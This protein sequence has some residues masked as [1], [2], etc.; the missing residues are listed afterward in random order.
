MQIPPYIKRMSQPNRDIMVEKRKLR[1]TMLARRRGLAHAAMLSANQSVARH[2]GDHPILAFAPSL[3]GYIAIQGELDVLPVFDAMQRFR[4]ITA[5]PCI[6]EGGN[7]QFRTWSRGEPLVRHVSLNVQEP[8]ATAPTIIPTVV[9]VP[10]LAFDGDG[11]RLGY[12]AG[13][14]DRTMQQM[15]Q[16]PTP[17][18]FIGVGHSAQE[19]DQIPV[20]PHDERLDGILTELGVSMFA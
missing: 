3:A 9:L 13:Y 20:E 19:V 7:L 17:P 5:L 14:Y 18:L 11:Y 15:R 10:L 1:Q 2:Y 12:G 4:K 8:A 16:F 6:T